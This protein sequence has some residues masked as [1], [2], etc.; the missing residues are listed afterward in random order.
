M[1]PAASQRT[2]PG[3]SYIYTLGNPTRPVVDG[4]YSFSIKR[5]GTNSYQAFAPGFT[6]PVFTFPA[7]ETK[8]GYTEGIDEST[9]S[10]EVY[11]NDTGTCPE[12][13]FEF[14][15]PGPW[16]FNL[17]TYGGYSEQGEYGHTDYNGDYYTQSLITSSDWFVGF[18]NDCRVSRRSVSA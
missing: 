7:R 8:K 14:T 11:A 2:T 4:V 12:S 3:G 10:N 17:Y 9:Y 16:L 5:T 1:R 13:N 18:P 15:S 6:S